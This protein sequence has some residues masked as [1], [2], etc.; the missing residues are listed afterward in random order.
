MKVTLIHDKDSQKIRKRRE[1]LQSDKR[2]LLEPKF[3]FILDAEVL[4]NFSLRSATRQ[5][6][7]GLLSLNQYCTGS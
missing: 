4:K 7:F 1:L 2:P 3:N 5:K 6:I